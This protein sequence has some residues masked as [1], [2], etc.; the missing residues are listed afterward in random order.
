MRT[1]SLPSGSRG[2]ARA[3]TSLRAA[4]RGAFPSAVLAVI[5]AG[6]A[7]AVA[8]WWVHTP[9]I[10]GL[11]DWLTNAGRVT[12]LLSRNGEHSTLAQLKAG[13]PAL[14]Q[15]LTVAGKQEVGRIFAGK[16]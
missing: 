9:S 10:H 3:I 11:G 6:A 1:G 5:G 8:L 13:D 16:A 2:P 7:T 14:I 4:L 15:V 12:G